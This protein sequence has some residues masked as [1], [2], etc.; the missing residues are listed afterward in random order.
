MSILRR[1]LGIFVMLAGVIG[2]LLS[3]AG[4]VG[5]IMVRPRLTEGLNTTVDTLYS[6]LDTSQR[7]MTITS[8]ALGATINSV[9]ALS[10]MLGTTAVT[11][12]E[13]QP[14]I[15]EVSTLMGE[16]LPTTFR[17]ATDSLAAA[18][19]A[20]QSLESAI[21]SF[22]TF[23]TVMGATPLLS[24]FMP[25]ST[26]SYNPEVP[27]AESLGALA[28]SIEEMPG[29]LEQMAANLETTDDNLLLIQSNLVT[30][31]ENVALISSS[32]DHY[33]SMIDESKASMDNLKTLLG[34]VQ[35]NLPTI[36]NIATLVIGLF[37]LWLLATQV[38]IFSQGWELY[39][40]TAGRMDNGKTSDQQ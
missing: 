13:T 27:L 19:E 12:A 31:S 15:T 40:G 28:T 33:R 18:E 38:V 32:L 20:A 29:T 7:T 2:L 10:D 3:I 17:A 30:M 39:H 35:E 11:V 25:P 14:V 16:T 26:T 6:S 24:V 37:M 1:F 34:D 5:I 21:M 22:E 9:D 4:L 23:R 36:L 8:D